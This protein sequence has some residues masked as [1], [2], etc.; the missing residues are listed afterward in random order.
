MHLLFFLLAT[1]TTVLSG[2][3]L[4]TIWTGSAPIV[5]FYY[6]L[7]TTVC[8]LFTHCFVFFYFIGTGQ[9]IREG[10][11]AHRLDGDAIKK[12]KKFKGKTFPFALFSMIFMIVAAVVGGGIRFGSSSKTAHLVWIIVALLFNFFSFFQEARVILQNR[13]LMIALNAKVDTLTRPDA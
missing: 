11:L 13:R 2:L 6:G 5:H 1:A 4:G 12:T 3:T 9:G 7:A 10:V 8:C